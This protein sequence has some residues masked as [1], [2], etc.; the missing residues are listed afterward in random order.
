MG[1]LTPAQRRTFALAC[2]TIC[3]PLQAPDK[4]A[5]GSRPV[6]VDYRRATP[7]DLN[8]VS[9]IETALDAEASPEEKNK[10]RTAL[11]SLENPAICLASTG[12]ATPFGKRSAHGRERML[13]A[14]STSRLPLLRQAFQTIK[15][16]A[17][18]SFFA[19]PDPQTGG[20]NP[21]ALALG[22]PAPWTPPAQR[23]TPANPDHPLQTTRVTEDMEIEA[24]ACVVGSGA[25]GGVVAA[26]LAEA[27]YRVAVL[28][29]GDA[30]NEQ[31]HV[32]DEEAGFRQLFAK[33]GLLTSADGAVVVLA[34][35]TLGGGTTVNWMTCFR[36]SDKLLAQWA[37]ASGVASL[38]GPELQAGLDAI[39]KRINVNKV[40]SR[41]NANNEA[42]VRGAAALGWHND[43]QARN[44]KGC[45]DCGLCTFGCPWGAKQGT[46]RT[47]LQDAYDAGAEIITCATAER[48][49]FDG[50]RA[51]GVEARVG[52]PDALP[53]RTGRPGT[54]R[55]VVRAPLVVV[56]AG[57]IESPALLLR[58]GLKHS[59]LGK[60]L[61]LHPSIVDIGV[62]DEE[63]AAWTGPLQTA[64]SNQFADMDGHG[65]GFK[66]EV[67]PIYPGLGASALPWESGESYKLRM[68]ELK[69]SVSLL[70]LTRDRASGRVTID[71]WGNPVIH[72][73]LSKTDAQHLMR[74]VKEGARLLL[75]AG[76]RDV[77]TLHTRLTSITRKEKNNPMAWE[78]FDARVD[79]LGTGP[80]NLMLFSAHQ[81]G[82]CRMG[83]DPATSVTDERGRV[84]GYSG[85]YVADASVFPQASGVNPM[86]TIMGF[87]HWIGSRLAG[88]GR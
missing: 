51:A 35:R 83:A 59:A 24:D 33:Q 64:H 32:P 62:F 79:R 82:T 84:H 39:E 41:L 1:F 36:P 5:A 52:A 56:A 12:S 72:Y 46:M 71:K 38:T 14:W 70:V 23:P 20:P 2:D 81:M 8:A 13:Q 80:N 27:G 37:A 17:G 76:A 9:L 78:R 19:S 88:E 50:K 15:R 55:L 63:I 3:P 60:H 53:R 43:I 21:N 29:S 75:A 44:S 65:F 7:S 66:F 49:I 74:G 34:G 16:L 57:G 31:S 42:L 10:L 77:Y 22:Y 73:T 25:G 68:L 86:I 30:F 6:P 18:Y 11:N 28:E 4:S 40:E 85:L 87:A 45:G 54:H 69:R 67:T 61:Y 47:Y 58:S 48:V 26:L